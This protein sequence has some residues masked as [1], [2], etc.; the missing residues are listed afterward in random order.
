MLEPSER[1]EVYKRYIREV[2]DFPKK[3]IGFKDITP[4][5]ADGEIFTEVVDRIAGICEENAL[6]ADVIV[7]PEARGFIFGAALACR[8]RIGFVPIRKPGKLPWKTCSVVYK[9]EYGTDTIQMHTDAVRSGQ[10]VLIVD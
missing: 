8:L 4:L 7:C 1:D 2:P 9:L 6:A 5:L 3:G 10:R